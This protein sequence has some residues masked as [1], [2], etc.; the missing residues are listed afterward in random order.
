VLLKETQKNRL[1]D[2]IGTVVDESK[3]LVQQTIISK[4]YLNFHSNYT[5]LKSFLEKIETN[6]NQELKNKIRQLPSLPS[7][8]KSF[9]GS[10]I[11]LIFFLSIINP[12][13]GILIL[14][15][16][17]PITIPTLIILIVINKGLK[18]KIYSVS[19]LTQEIKNTIEW[20]ENKIN[21]C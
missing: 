6:S 4:N 1:L 17:F 14:I 9:S 20:G 19:Y 5:E 3:I 2:Q 7:P 8:N 11:Q 12:I 21:V 10:L 18:N 13:F 16:L 15:V